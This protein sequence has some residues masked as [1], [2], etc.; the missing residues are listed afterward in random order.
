MYLSLLASLSANERSSGFL[1][2]SHDTPSIP[3][4][5]TSEPFPRPSDKIKWEGAANGMSEDLGIIQ[6]VDCL[7]AADK[8]SPEGREKLR[9]SQREHM[10]P[11]VKR[12]ALDSLAMNAE[13]SF[14][15][16]SDTK[17]WKR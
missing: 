4:M 5:A 16:V 15:G 17:V 13:S 8:L 9:H 12:R 1:L 14:E 11:A 3:I 7:R 2:V 10:T 6:Q